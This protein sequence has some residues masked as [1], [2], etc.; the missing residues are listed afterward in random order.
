MSSREE[1]SEPRP[2]AKLELEPGVYELPTKEIYLV[3][4][5]QE[6]THVYALRLVET[7]SDRITESGATVKF[8]FQYERGAIYRILPEHRMSLERG[9]ELMIRYGRCIVCGHNLKVKKSV[10]RGIGPVCIKA[11]G[12][13]EGEPQ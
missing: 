4:P 7:P 10:E 1:S 9:K 6:M 8:E 13:R 3:K 5:N 12:Q 2:I 11:F